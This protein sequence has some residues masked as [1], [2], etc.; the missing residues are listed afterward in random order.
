MT[1]WQVGLEMIVAGSED[2]SQ[3]RASLLEENTVPGG[4]HGTAG[5]RELFPCFLGWSWRGGR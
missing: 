1:G 2:K 5:G 4:V 3:K